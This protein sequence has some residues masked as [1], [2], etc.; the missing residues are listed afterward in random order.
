MS[1]LHID[2]FYKDTAK[3]LIQLY[4]SFP[5]RSMVLAEEISGLD[6]PDEYGLHGVRHQASFGAALWLAQSGYIDYEDTIQQK[7]LDQAILTHKAFTLLSARSSLTDSASVS[8]TLPSSVQDSQLS[9]IHQ[10]RTALK[11]GSSTQLRAV[12]QNLLTE[13]NAH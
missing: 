2:D 7:G 10:L 11:S 4:R 6:Q 3:I 13:S 12:V 8:S 9:N 1:D 5:R